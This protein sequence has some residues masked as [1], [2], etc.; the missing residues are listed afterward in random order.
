MIAVTGAR[1][2][3]GLNH[4]LLRRNRHTLRLLQALGPGGE[5]LSR[6]HA[7]EIGGL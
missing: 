4:A 5:L 1:P 6:T 2:P 3:T 7:V